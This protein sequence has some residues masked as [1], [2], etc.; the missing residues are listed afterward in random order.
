MTR[1]SS[2]AASTSLLQ[3][4]FRTRSELFDLETQVGSGKGSQDYKGI[5]TDTQRLINLENTRSQLQQYIK[6][7][8]Q[9]DLRLNIAA[10][11]VEGLNDVVRDFRNVMLDFETSDKKDQT[12]VKDIQD[13]AFRSLQSLQSLLNT[14]VDGRFLFSGARVGTQPVDFGL[15]SLNDF[16]SIFDGSRVQVSTTRDSHLENFSFNKDTLTEAADWLKFERNVGAT[17]QVDRITVAGTVE[18]GD[19]FTVTLNG[20]AFNFTAADTST[21]NVAIGLANAINAG[22]E[23]VTAGVPGGGIFTLTADVAGTALTSA[24]ATT[25][26]NN[27]PADAQNIATATPT[28][29]VPGDVPGGSLVTASSFA[30]VD[31][32]KVFGTVQSDDKFTVTIN[33]TAFNATAANAPAVAAALVLAINT[34]TA[35]PVT[36]ADLGGGVFTLTA[37]VAN[38]GFTSAVATTESDNGTADD[39]RIT[40]EPT[41]LNVPGKFTNVAVGSTITISDTGGVNDGT[42]EVIAKT[43]STLSIRTEQLTDE[44]ANTVVITYQDPADSTKTI[45]LDTTLAF[46]RNNN[47]MARPTVQ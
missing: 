15:T 28:A 35:E 36:A 39:Q 16:Q 42:F 25:E 14:E 1:I 6:N 13:N 41:T 29:N 8:E 31:T 44:A 46:T 10:T 4:I 37:D 18:V 2:L 27:D 22:A 47:T 7:N 32:I 9:M 11:A 17:A 19:K 40:T 24:V 5:G 3:Q 12:T 38:T 21:N 30:Q 20:V 43:S 34:S 45:T 26:S 33:G 23:P